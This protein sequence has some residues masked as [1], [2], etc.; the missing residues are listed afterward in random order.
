VQ[1]ALS[2]FEREAQRGVCD[3]GRYRCFYSTW[4]KGPPLVFVPGM[5]NNGRSFLLLAAHLAA[6]F[7]CIAYDYPT[8]RGDGA[9]LQRY[10]HADLVADVFALLD[11]LNVNQSYIL[12]CSFGS[13][14]AVAA[15]HQ[16]PKRLPRAILQGGFAR[17]PLAP[18]E[19][20]AARLGRV[21]PG[22][23][24]RFPLYQRVFRH[25]HFAPFADRPEEFW[26]HCVE[27]IGKHTTRVSARYALLLHKTDVRPLLPEIR[28]PVLLVTGDRDPL[29]RQPC[30]DELLQGLPNAGHIEIEGC[31]HMPLF[32]HPGELARIVCRFLTPAHATA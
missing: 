1:E 8:G 29:V 6:H 9:R 18:A 3:T 24:A 17:R 12:G 26:R 28:Q 4:G 16:Q 21:W 10:S 5:G 19:R 14:I 22:K 15:M 25:N 20:L 31:G 13:T 2:R 27:H 7:R 30:T 11:H 32:S 23:L